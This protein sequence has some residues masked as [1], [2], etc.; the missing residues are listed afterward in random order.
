MIFLRLF[1]P[2]LPGGGLGWGLVDYGLRAGGRRSPP[3]AGGFGALGSNGFAA[4]FSG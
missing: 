3:A 4:G 2:P 1:L